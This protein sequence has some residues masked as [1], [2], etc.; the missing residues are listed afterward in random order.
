MDSTTKQKIVGIEDTVLSDLFYI[1][2]VW[3]IVYGSFKVL[4]GLAL[5]HLHGRSLID[6]FSL[7]MRHEIMQDPHDILVGF[8]RHWLAHSPAEVTYFLA[9]YFLFW[10]VVDI[11][12]SVCI[13]QRRLWAYPV[14]ATLIALFIAYSCFRYTHTHSAVLLGIIVIDITVLVLIVREYRRLHTQA[15]GLTE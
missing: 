12:L 9:A 1:G 15:A 4:L 14:T 6:I 13:L 8:I 5:L 11:F 2:M 10:G 7:V 3:R